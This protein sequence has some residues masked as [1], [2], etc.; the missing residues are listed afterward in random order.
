MGFDGRCILVTGGV[1]GI[2]HAI[3]RKCASAGAVVAVADQNEAGARDA[4][5]AIT[6]SGSKAVAIRADISDPEDVSWM[7]TFASALTG[8]I[9]GM[10]HCAG[11]AANRYGTPE[12]VAEVAAF[13]LSEAAAYVNGVV[14]PI[15]GAFMRSGVIK[16]NMNPGR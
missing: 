9:N 14:M 5:A 11:I 6:A 1:S 10:A 15:D 12:E 16:R 8:R 13:L 2:G 7:F 3:A 4:A